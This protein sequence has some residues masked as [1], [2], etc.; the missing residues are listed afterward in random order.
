MEYAKKLKSKLNKI[1]SK[2][3]IN[4]SLFVKNPKCD[5]TRKRI[6]TFSEIIKIILGMGGNSLNK[7]L[8]DYF[9]YNEKCVTTSAFVQQ[10]EKILPFAFEFLFK[11]FNENCVTK[12]LFK[13]YRLLAVDGSDI[14]MCGD[15]NDKESYFKPKNSNKDYGLLH[16]NALYDLINK[17]YIDVIIQSRR[18]MNEQKA[19]ID[20]VKGYNSDEKAIFICDRGYENYNAFCNIAESGQKYVIRVKDIH[21]TGIASSLNLPNKPFDL[22]LQR[23]LTRQQTNYV[24]ENKNIYK[25]L[26]SNVIFDFLEPKSKQTYK[27][28]FRLV[29][30]KITEDTYETLITNLSIDEFSIDELKELYHL[31][32]GIEVSFRELKYSL[33]L[34]NFHS[35]KVELIH[36]EIY[37]KLIMYNFCELITSQITITQDKEHIYKVNFDTAVN[38]CINFYKTA[39]HKQPPNVEALI[40]KFILPVRPKRAYKR[41]VKTKGYQGFNYRIS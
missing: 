8:L 3:E 10:R 18:T 35:K 26:P 25:F 41:N 6:L 2:M 28:N 16:V 11:E 20:M 29:R 15:K 17:N 23:L 19:L 5:F 38:I 34:V 33:G 14:C 1:I 22:D 24:K 36:Q 37:A 21:S 39:K 31:R 12:R 27:F 4:S 7:E 9:E 32:W 40:K 30:F 13:G